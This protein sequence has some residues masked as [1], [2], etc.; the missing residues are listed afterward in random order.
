MSRSNPATQK[1]VILSTNP[2]FILHNSISFI[3]IYCLYNLITKLNQLLFNKKHLRKSKR[4][5][6]QA[7]IERNETNLILR[8]LACNKVP[9]Y[10]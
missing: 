10:C 3:S 2:V 8:A 6:R 5:G 1:K 7:D 9:I 4:A